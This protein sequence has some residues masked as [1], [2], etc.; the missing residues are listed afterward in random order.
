MIWYGSCSLDKSLK[1]SSS[2]QFDG[3]EFSYCL[4]GTKIM[5]DIGVKNLGAEVGQ[6]LI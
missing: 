1:P 2:D 5:S 6:T 4:I 3:L